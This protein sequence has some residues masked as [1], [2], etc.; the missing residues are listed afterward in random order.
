[1]LGNRAA[2]ALAAMMGMGGNIYGTG[3]LAA[4]AGLGG[5]PFCA[6]H[7]CH[8]GDGTCRNEAVKGQ[9]LCS[10][11]KCSVERCWNEAKNQPRTRG[12]GMTCEIHTRGAGGFGPGGGSGGWGGMP[13]PIGGLGDGGGQ[14][15]YWRL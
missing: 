11:H 6:E 7:T 9:R 8:A 12:G 4:L 10:A 5:G 1:M 3:A 13:I 14:P 15:G 2:S